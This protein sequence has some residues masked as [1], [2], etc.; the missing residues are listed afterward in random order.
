MQGFVDCELNWNHQL[1]AWEIEMPKL[2]DYLKTADAAEM[3]G[4]SQ[5]T[6]RK[7]AAEGKIPVRRNPANG[8]RLFKRDDLETFLRQAGTPTPTTPKKP[9]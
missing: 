8:Y 1:P 5:N 7:W 9:K 2:S 6:L 3:L 4:C